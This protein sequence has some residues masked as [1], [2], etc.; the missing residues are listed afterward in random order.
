MMPFDRNAPRNET[1]SD[2]PKPA[3]A[4][5]VRAE[6]EDLTNSLASLFTMFGGQVLDP[7]PDKRD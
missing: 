1:P 3:P 2:T 4:W 6:R 5:P 7:A